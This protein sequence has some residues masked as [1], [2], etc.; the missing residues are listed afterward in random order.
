MKK[1]LLVLAFTVAA[2]LSAQA[3]LITVLTSGNRLLTIDSA[4]PGTLTKPAVSVTGLASGDTLVGIDYRPATGVLYALGS[5]GSIY[6]IDANTGSATLAGP[7][8]QFTLTGTRFGF[9]F[10]PTVDRLRII[11]DADQN[12]RVNPNNG[13]LAATDGN[14]AFAPTDPNVGQNPNAVGAAYTNSFPGAAATV[15]YDIDSNLDILVAQDPANA[16]TLFTIGAL[17]TDTSDVVGFDISPTSGVAYASFTTSAAP[18]GTSLYTVNLR[19]GAA[20]ASGSP[21]LIAPADLLAESVVD[22]AAV[23]DNGTRLRNI[24]TRGRVGSG[25]DVLIAGFITRGRGPAGVAGTYII[26]ALGPSL[27]GMGLGTPLSD[28]IV[29]VYDS[30]GVALATNDDFSSSPD[31]AAITAA[32]LAPPDGVESAVRITLAPGAYTAVVTGKGGA[33]GVALVEVYEQ[34]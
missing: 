9:D 16:G 26:R 5:A 34:P 29:T 14:I 32:Q 1:S 17:G 31:A 24:S 25:D 2:L 27:S 15:L 13:A 19:S 4:T 28:P 18:A 23:A 20:T 10:N 22:I 7:A 6:S 21:A 33:A 3:E 30:S 11:S 12:L 8:G